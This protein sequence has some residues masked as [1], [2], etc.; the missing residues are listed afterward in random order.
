ML[1]KT[2]MYKPGWRLLHKTTRTLRCVPAQSHRGYPSLPRDRFDGIP[3]ARSPSVRRDGANPSGITSAA[4]RGTVSSGK[5]DA[6]SGGVS[7]GQYNFTLLPWHYAD[8]GR[9]EQTIGSDYVIP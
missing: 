9:H 4:Q 5:C 8:R 6:Y 7:P 3:L 1:R 2:G